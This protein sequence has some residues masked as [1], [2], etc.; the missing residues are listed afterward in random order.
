M[1]HYSRY[2]IELINRVAGSISYTAVLIKIVVGREVRL[3]IRSPVITTRQGPVWSAL[4]AEDSLPERFSRPPATPDKSRVA[5][6]ALPDRHG[7]PWSGPSRFPR[8]R[9]STS[10]ISRSVNHH[11]MTRRDLRRSADRRRTM[12]VQTRLP[13]EILRAGDRKRGSHAVSRRWEKESILIRHDESIREKRRDTSSK[14]CSRSSLSNLRWRWRRWLHAIR[15][16]DQ[17]SVCVAWR[18]FYYFLW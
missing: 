13:N 9:V 18:S 6:E 10:R 11:R 7:R 1:S 17:K 5:L 14:N 8:C 12:T 15:I 3:F 2:S 16:R 4:R